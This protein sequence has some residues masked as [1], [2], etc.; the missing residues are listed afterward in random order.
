MREPIERPIRHGL[1]FALIVNG[2]P[3]AK[4][5][6]RN[7]MKKQLSIIITGLLFAASFSLAADTQ[8][9]KADR[10]KMAEMHTKMA[11]CLESDKAISDCHGEMM[12]SCK[13]LMGKSACPMMGEMGHMKGM[14]GQNMMMDNK[15]E[16]PDKKSKK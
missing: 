15:N 14:R 6:E 5:R 3:N 13:E 8:P 2:K 12:K 4:R 11:T 7:Y 16:T 10:Q 9:S 1:S